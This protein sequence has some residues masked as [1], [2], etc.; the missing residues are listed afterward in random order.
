MGL[1]F[2]R[3]FISHHSCL[4]HR[5]L[6]HEV[7]A[8]NYV[9]I[10]ESLCCKCVTSL[11][12]VWIYG[13]ICAWVFKFGLVYI[14]HCSSNTYSRSREHL[15]NTFNPRELTFFT[16]VLTSTPPPD[17]LTK[18]NLTSSFSHE[19]PSN[20]TYVTLASIVGDVVRLV[21]VLIANLLG[22]SFQFQ[23]VNSFLSLFYIAFYLQ[24]MNR[25]K[26]VSIDNVI[27][28]SYRH[29]YVL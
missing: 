3:I 20:Y 7:V 15:K 5:S 13:T 26:E 17:P 8:F 12:E 22:F 6:A 10:T 18:W 29:Y 23:F 25:L 19:P 21:T 1:K 24:D 28:S 16:S 4:F 11:L 2:F 9:D 14:G 27:S